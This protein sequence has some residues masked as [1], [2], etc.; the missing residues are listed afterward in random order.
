VRRGKFELE[1][2]RQAIVRLEKTGATLD[3]KF[4]FSSLF[5]VN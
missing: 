3:G 1:A 4:F 5:K 2:P